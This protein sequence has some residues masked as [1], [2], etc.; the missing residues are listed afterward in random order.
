MGAWIA[1]PLTNLPG[2]NLTEADVEGISR[3][4]ATMIRGVVTGLLGL[5]TLLAVLFFIYI[6]FRLAKA[7]DE[8]KRKEAK[9]QMIYSVVAI[10]G[11]VILIVLFNTII[12][13]QIIGTSTGTGTGTGTGTN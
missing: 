4:V 2:E 9:K 10:I 1:N 6:G 7:E 3:Q 13:N 12:M 5:F 11:V 8:S